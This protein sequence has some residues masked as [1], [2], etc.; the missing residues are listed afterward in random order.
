MKTITI[1]A[2]LALAPSAALAIVCNA[3]N[4]LRALRANSAKASPFCSTYTLPPPNQ[5]LPTYVSAY[6]ASRV[7]SA[8]SCFITP[9]P[10]TLA[11]TTTSLSTTPTSST[12]STTTSTTPT[13][14]PPGQDCKGDYIR[15]GDFQTLTNGKPDPWVF[16]P[17]TASN[18]GSG[19]YTS[20]SATL[21]SSGGDNYASLSVT[22][23]QSETGGYAGT[24]IKQSIPGLCYGV[25]Y[26]LTYSSQMTITGGQYRRG[27]NAYY[28]LD[29]IGQL[30]YIGGPS[31]DIPPFQYETRSYTFTYY[32]NGRPDTLTISFSCSAPGG[33]YTVDDVSLVGAG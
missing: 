5:P 21:S 4:V 17:E 27:C 28:S 25:Q 16:A 1:T 30:F 12:T 14:T 24:D 29:S 26:N 22:N 13:Q 32:G 6:P 19:Q 23:G 18:P 20:T 10:T 11:T 2:L 15:N 31:G 8:C 3:D 9:G 33:S 7:S